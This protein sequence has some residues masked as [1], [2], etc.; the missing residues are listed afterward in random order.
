MREDVLYV[1]GSN[2]TAELINLFF[3]HEGHVYN[4]LDAEDERVWILIG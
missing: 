3:I 4:M 2:S 1:P